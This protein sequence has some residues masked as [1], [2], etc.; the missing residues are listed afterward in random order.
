MM[1]SSMTK[2]THTQDTPLC[3]AKSISFSGSCVHTTFNL[4]FDFCTIFRWTRIND[5]NQ[6]SLKN[7]IQS[8]RS[9]DLRGPV[10][11]APVR[12]SFYDYKL[13]QI[14][15]YGNYVLQTRSVWSEK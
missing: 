6:M 8:G 14:L 2:V 1:C 15:T 9:G 10:K 3:A 4:L 11:L 5:R 7:A 12:T 13:L